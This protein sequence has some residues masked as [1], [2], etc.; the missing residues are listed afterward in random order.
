MRM[1]TLF[2]LTCCGLGLGLSVAA[3]AALGDPEGWSLRTDYAKP[4]AFLVWAPMEDGSRGL[5][6][7]C[8]P[9]NFF[10]VRSEDAP[11]DLVGK[12]ATLLLGAGETRYPIAGEVAKDANSGEVFFTATLSGDAKGLAAVQRRLMPLLESAGPLRYA[13]GSGN[14]STESFENSTPISLQQLRLL[15][16]RFKEA[17]FGAK[18]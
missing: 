13:I 2:W 1:R 17:C 15:M 7:D 9:G 11:E 4:R 10:G 18:K 12:P 16:E 6:F 3:L 14:A 8:V 5:A